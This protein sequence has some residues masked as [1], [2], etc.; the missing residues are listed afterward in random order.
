[1][2]PPGGGGGSGYPVPMA[3]RERNRVVVVIVAVLVVAIAVYG[4][5]ALLAPLP[6]TS[7]E[8]A[9]PAGVA[10]STPPPALPPAGSSGVTLG[11]SESP[12]A[13][14]SAE[15]VPI[16]AIAKVVAALV[17]LDARPLDAGRAGPAIPVTADDFASYAKYSAA[18]TRAIRVVTG[19]T[20]T[21]REAL[22]A[23]LIASSNNHAEMLARWAFGSIDNYLTAAQDWLEANGLASIHV[24]DATGLSEESVGSGA[25]LAQIAA[26]AMA[27]PLIAETVTADQIVTT[28]GITFENTISYSASSG[29]TGISRSYT[30][31]AGVCLL[32]ALTVTVGDQAVPVYGAI[33]GEPSYDALDADFAALSGSLPASVSEHVIVADGAVAGTYTTAWGQTA[34]AVTREAI[35][36]IGFSAEATPAF[37][38]TLRPIVTAAKD[39][40]VGTLTVT[41]GEGEQP[42]TLVLDQA[43]RDPGPIWRLFS[44]GVVVPAFFGS[45]TGSG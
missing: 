34:N 24:V 30:D 6:S 8:V 25:D 37:D 15:A 38:V 28:R 40:K 29:V 45:I 1:M 10:S 26:L 44:P 18:G 17:V 12:I 23:V 7:G 19:D 16:A 42:V 43:V 11:T 39:T 33:V 13:G 3:G 21:E 20:S 27:D 2:R 5:I 4:P 36:A 41:G 14:G 22:Q 31:E 32:F 35:T 9:A